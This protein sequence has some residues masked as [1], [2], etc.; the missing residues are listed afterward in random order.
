MTVRDDI[1]IYEVMTELLDRYWWRDYRQKLAGRFC[2]DMLI[3]RVSQV[4]LL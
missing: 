1:V 2:Q 4:E 3:V